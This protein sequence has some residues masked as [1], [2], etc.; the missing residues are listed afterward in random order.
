MKYKLFYKK[1]KEEKTGGAYWRSEDFYEHLK[2]TNF[3]TSYNFLIKKNIKNLKILEAG[4]GI[5]RWIIP[6]AKKE[7]DVTGIE[8][9]EE[10]INIIRN[11]YDV[12]N[13]NLVRGDIFDMPFNDEEFDLVISLGVLEHFEKKEVLQ[14]AIL[15]HKR[16]LKKN[17]HFLITVPYFSLIRLLFHLPFIKLVSFVRKL[18]KTKEYFTEY[19]YS[20][21]EFRK[22]LEENNLEI[23]DIIYDEL[24]PPYNFG[25]MDFPIRKLFKSKNY[26]LN[27][28][29]KIFFNFFWKFAPFVISG[30][31]AFYCK[32]K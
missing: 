25:F 8:I 23:I 29:G 5:G 30:G 6:L 15:E 12:K 26:Q 19:R 24:L 32:K 2:I 22:I 18:K 28:F 4:C 14:A 11:N 9:E 31:I 21:K 10:A 3:Q 16:V 20:K 7:N 27:K 13:I 1:Q 17:G